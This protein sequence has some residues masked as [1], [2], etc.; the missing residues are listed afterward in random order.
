MDYPT[1]C[2][3]S[4]YIAFLML[5]TVVSIH[6]HHFFQQPV[7]VSMSD[8]TLFS[9]SVSEIPNYCGYVLPVF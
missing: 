7:G 6:N 4:S 8:N 2:N 9:G 1:T 5:N 3:S